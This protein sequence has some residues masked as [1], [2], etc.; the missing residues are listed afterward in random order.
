VR[1]GEI[2]ITLFGLASGGIV[3]FAC[4]RFVR[5]QALKAPDAEERDA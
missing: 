4:I 3:T 2:V 1:A 5:Q